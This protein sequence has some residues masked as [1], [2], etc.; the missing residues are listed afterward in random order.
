M[1]K[2]LKSIF[3]QIKCTHV[4]SKCIQMIQQNDTNIYMCGGKQNDTACCVFAVAAASVEQ[5][6]RTGHGVA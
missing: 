3:E 4:Y 6:H 2:L 1:C 5:L